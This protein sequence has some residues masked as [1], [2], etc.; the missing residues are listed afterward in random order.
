M[1]IFTLNLILI[2][3]YLY[4]ETDKINIKIGHTKILKTIKNPFI[5]ILAI[6]VWLVLYPVT[7][8]NFLKYCSNL[9]N[10]KNNKYK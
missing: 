1:R 6:Q 2:L 9:Y 7:H 10:L 4:F 8:L 5:C 3:A